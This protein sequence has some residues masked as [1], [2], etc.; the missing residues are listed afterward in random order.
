MDD[1]VAH[2]LS[3][4]DPSIIKPFNV[5]LDAGSHPRKR[6]HLDGAHREP[7]RELADRRLED[8]RQRDEDERDGCDG[9]RQLNHAREARQ[10][11]REQVRLDHVVDTATRA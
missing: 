4:I 1:Y 6:G 7:V 10:G 5:V 2:V 3:F 9:D 8:R 11:G